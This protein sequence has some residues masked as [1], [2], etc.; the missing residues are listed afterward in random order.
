MR[1]RLPSYRG[2]IVRYGGPSKEELLKAREKWGEL[3]EHP[4]LRNIPSGL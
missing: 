4:N 3:A 2:T 1:V